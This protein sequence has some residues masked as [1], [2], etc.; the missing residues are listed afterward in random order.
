VKQ[1]FF[2]PLIVYA[3]LFAILN[4][5][6]CNKKHNADT[7]AVSFEGT[8]SAHPLTT[9]INEASGIADSKINPGYLWAEED[10]GNPPQLYLLNHAATAVKIIYIKGAANIDWEDIALASGPD[11]SKKYLY[12][13]DIGD[14]GA[15]HT[16]SAFL[17]FEEPA[18]STDTVRAFDIINFIYAD[19]P[20]DAEAFLVDDNSK[21]IYIISKRDAKSRLYKLSYPYNTTGMNTAVFVEALPYNGVVS[22]AAGNDGKGIIIKTYQALY[23]YSRVAG[24]TI[25]Q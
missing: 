10:S 21:D 20:R 3:C 12:V 25:A 18:A 11:P 8:P 6:G 7:A 14:N 15:V 2:S 16:R 13:A 19:G 9:F 24:E 17:R 22:A 5:A 4:A 1:C 23:Y